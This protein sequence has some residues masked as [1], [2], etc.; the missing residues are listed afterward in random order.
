MGAKK[1]AR[2]LR[3][4]LE[5]EQERLVRAKEALALLSDGGTAAR[6]I[7]VESASQIEPHARA[8]ECF[9]CGDHYRVLEHQALHE[10]AR[11]IRLVTVVSPQCG[12]QR[13]VYFAIAPALSN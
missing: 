2:T 3:R 9:A 8:M 12:R 6:P 7:E 4:E 11:A 10:G 13:R 5:R 1:R